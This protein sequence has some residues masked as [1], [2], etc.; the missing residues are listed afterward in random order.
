[1]Q[2]PKY[3]HIPQ[4]ERQKV[5]NKVKEAEDSVL[6]KAE[7][8]K[9]LPST[10]DPIIWVAD[11]THTKEVQQACAFPP[12]L[13]HAAP[14]LTLVTLVVAELGHLCL[15]HHEQTEAQA[16]CPCAQGR[17]QKGRKCP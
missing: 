9:T 17:A 13:R 1:M 3:E 14:P 2:D 15:D 4:E 11:I 7:Q 16:C 12:N 8:Q 10:A 5:L 6:P